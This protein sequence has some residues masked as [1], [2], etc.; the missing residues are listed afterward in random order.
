M[1]TTALIS[2]ITSVCVCAVP[3]LPEVPADLPALSLLQVC[4][5]TVTVVG[6]QVAG[7]PSSPVACPP[8]SYDDNA[9]VDGCR[10]W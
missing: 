4:S 9:V 5:G 3:A 6:G 7:V 2:A 8:G 1:R 10:P